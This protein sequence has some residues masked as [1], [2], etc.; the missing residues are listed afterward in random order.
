MSEKIFIDAKQ[1]LKDSF[2]LAMNIYKSGYKPNYIIG[3]WRGGTPIAIAIHEVFEYFNI[4]CN[5]MPIKT[6]SYYEI[7]IHDLD[8]Q[9]VGLSNIIRDINVDDNIL[10]IDDIFDTGL[11]M[12]KIS[13]ILNVCCKNIKIATMYFKPKNN[14]TIMVP[15]YYLYETDK[16]VVFP[17][18]LVGLT[19]DEIIK[20]KS[21]IGSILFSD[22]FFK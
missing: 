2:Q 5:H 8:V 16:W 6:S 21:D 15:D 18:E 7:G 17:H 20:N 14:K 22:D 11:T 1:L 3:L 9:I 10:I 4:K 13:N 19:E 12:D